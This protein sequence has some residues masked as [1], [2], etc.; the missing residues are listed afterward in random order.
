M[1]QVAGNFPL[2]Q[3]EISW[4][5]HPTVEISPNLFSQLDVLF[6]EKKIRPKSS[7]KTIQ[8]VS[9]SHALVTFRL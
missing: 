8:T 6:F 1:G 4:E 2:E 5:N 7:Q 9:L 3:P